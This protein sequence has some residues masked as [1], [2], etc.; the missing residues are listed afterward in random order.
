MSDNRQPPEKNCF[1]LRRKI[2]IPK[3]WIVVGGD[4]DGTRMNL[5]EGSFDGNEK[6]IR[7]QK[8]R[9]KVERLV[10][11]KLIK[12]DVLVVWSYS[13]PPVGVVIVLGFP[14]DFVWETIS[15]I[16]EKP[17]LPGT[18]RTPE[19]YRTGSPVSSNVGYGESNPLD[20]GEVLNEGL[21]IFIDDLSVGSSLLYHLYDA[22]ESIIGSLSAW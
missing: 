12:D 10:P 13:I 15:Q 6:R 11:I 4:D 20:T 2:A 5:R 21:R 3:T 7:V 8:L 16:R 14:I 1:S 22:S 17:R 19:Y 9:H 18:G